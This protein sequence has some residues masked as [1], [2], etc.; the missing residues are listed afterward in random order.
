MLP[1]TENASPG[2]ELPQPGHIVVNGNPLETC[3]GLPLSFCGARRLRAGLRP[4][5]QRDSAV[6]TSELVTG[7]NILL[8]KQPLSACATLAPTRQRRAERVGAA[9]NGVE[10][11]PL[12]ATARPK[13][14]WGC[15]SAATA[16]QAHC[17]RV[18]IVS[19]QGCHAAAAAA[20]KIAGSGCPAIYDHRSA[21]SAAPI[22]MA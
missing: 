15:A 17:A 9:V 12:A 20:D 14:H 6:S 21:R 19:L 1:R 11:L 3:L 16:P 22:A 10:R 4:R 5:L 2:S 18:P 7:V 13:T 8:A